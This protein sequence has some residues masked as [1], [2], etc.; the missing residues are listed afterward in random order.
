MFKIRFDRVL[1]A[2]IGHAKHVIEQEISALSRKKLA[3]LAV[4]PEFLMVREFPNLDSVAMD[5]VPLDFRV[6]GFL[7]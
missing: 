5:V 1:Q 6:D 4:Y 3:A 2:W 7:R